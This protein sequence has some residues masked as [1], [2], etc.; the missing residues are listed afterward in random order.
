MSRYGWTYLTVMHSPDQ[1][2]VAARSWRTSDGGTFASED[3]MFR[4][5]GLTGWELVA[6]RD[7]NG[8][9]YYYFKRARS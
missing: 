4:E 7:S 2:A 6:V 3:E 8:I 5:L 1:N 9:V